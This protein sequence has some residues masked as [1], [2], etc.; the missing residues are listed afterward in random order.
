MGNKLDATRIA[1][2]KGFT[3]V[4]D[5]TSTLSAIT[6]GMQDV[7]SWKKG[8]D[9]AEIKLKTDTAKAYQDA[10][11]LATERMTGNKTVDAAILKS[12][13][14]TQ[15]RLYDNMKMV[16]KGMQT[17][18]DNLIF[19][20]NASSSYDILSS[21]LQDYDANFQQAIKEAQGYV[22][23]ET[24]K[25][26]KP[27]AG[28]FQAAIQKFQTTLGNPNLYQILSSESGNL[29]INLFKTKIDTTTNTRQLV[30]DDDG[31]PIIDPT[32]SGIGA[33]TLLKGKNQ[34][35]P[36]V[37]MDDMINNALAEDTAISKAYQ[38]MVDEKGFVKVTVDDVRNNPDIKR[39]IDTA[40]ISGTTSVGQRMSI[41]MDN[42][43][44][45]M[46]QIPV[47]PNEVE[48]LK[49]QGIDLNEKIQYNYLNP[50]TG[51][52]EPGTYNKYAIATLD[53][54]S[55]V[56][57]SEETEESKIA[58]ARIFKSAI[59]AGLERKITGRTKTT[60]FA[61]D[62][63]NG[64]E[65]T[66][67]DTF[68]LIDQVVGDGNRDSLE[69][70]VRDGK[71]GVSD[72]EIIP[73]EVDSEG[74]EIKPSQVVFTKLDGTKTAPIPLGAGRNAVDVGKLIASELGFNAESYTNESIYKPG[75]LLNQGIKDFAKF[76][77]PK[78][79]YGGLGRLAIGKKDKNTIIYASQYI[80]K[81]DEDKM[82]S[83][84]QVVVDKARARY[85]NIPN[86]KVSF[87][88]LGGPNDEISITI[89]GVKYKNKGYT[90][91]NHKWLMEN[92]DRALMGETPDGKISGGSTNSGGGAL[93]N[94][95]KTKG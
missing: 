4:S 58:S 40:A 30:L 34:K 13:Q 12:L 5:P 93:D 2:E 95:G 39:L 19:R 74:T 17:P 83:Q 50:E 3:G 24:G 57:L 42:V 64:K 32:M 52:P 49:A 76:E 94:L 75:D 11:K 14:S 84:A 55:K 68:K 69:A 65:A 78:E 60:V 66:R 72:F 20:Q 15:D 22:D 89:D 92:L 36:R 85:A 35:A 53:P 10:K 70:I 33:S 26:V 54:M 29:D 6:K 90:S 43:P 31:N 91:D 79:E 77:T 67:K 21:Y 88:D 44:P 86:I 41:L 45:G 18:T 9:D 27:T 73:K 51:L 61:P 1:L 59:Y 16:Q 38:V 37:Y 47:M 62:R 46:E 7:A 80:E 48:G 71:N 82:A 63:S 87:D 23:E 28:A 81:A 25:F 8:I 56:W